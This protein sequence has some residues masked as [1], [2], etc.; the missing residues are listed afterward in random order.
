MVNPGVKMVLFVIYTTIALLSCSILLSVVIVIAITAANIYLARIGLFR[1]L[2]LML[3]PVS[4][5]FL[6]S[7]SAMVEVNPTSTWLQ[8]SLFGNTLG[9]TPSNLHRGLL[10]FA[11]SFSTI[12]VLYALILNTP[13]TDMLFVLRKLKVPGVLLDVMVLVYR[14]I[15]IFSDTAQSIYTSQKSRLGYRNLRTSLRSTGQL[16]GRIFVLGGVRAEHLYRSM[17][18]RC[19]NVKI[20]T[21]TS[22]WK[23][24][25]MFLLTAILL[26][27]VF[28]IALYYFNRSVFL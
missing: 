7:I 26:A 23:A 4:F 6:G 20:N 3:I 25:P 1:L 8:M 5:V 15:F 18:S 19:Y 21:L 17:E 16:G 22:Q 12:S 10:L 28:A 11:R 27:A 13:V 14:N 24:K 9:I 2:R